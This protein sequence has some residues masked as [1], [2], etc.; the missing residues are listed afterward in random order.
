M[1]AANFN[2]VPVEDLGSLGFI[3]TVPDQPC[4]ASSL[5]PRTHSR[6]VHH[7]E[8]DWQDQLDGLKNGCKRKNVFGIPIE[9]IDR[10]PLS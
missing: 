4:T 3:G 7:S 5:S 1:M 10:Q 2:L 6:D 9:R 8:I